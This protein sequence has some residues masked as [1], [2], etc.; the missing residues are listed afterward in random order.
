MVK[1]Y[2]K[3]IGPIDNIKTEGIQ[4][5]LHKNARILF[6]HNLANF[7]EDL[8]GTAK[9]VAL[10]KKGFAEL[11]NVFIFKKFRG[12]GFCK[13]LVSTMVTKYKKEFPDIKILLMVAEENTSAIKCY[14]K[15]GFKKF[16]GAVALWLIKR[17]SKKYPELSKKYTFQVMAI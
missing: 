6:I 4:N 11:M 13:Q 14:R 15:V 1:N 5:T 8:V 2:Q 9:I 3:E 10:P 7:N 17:F 16:D 12:K